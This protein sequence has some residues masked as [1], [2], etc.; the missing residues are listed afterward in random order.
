MK[1]ILLPFIMLVLAINCKAQLTIT[2]SLTTSQITTLL[3]GFGVTVSGL[4]VNCDPLAMGEFNGTSEMAIT[5]GIVLTT[6]SASA[7]AG[8]V[9]TT[10]TAMPGTA[11]DTDLD[12]LSGSTTFDACVLEFDCL[13]AGDTL[14]FN[15]SFGSEE[16]LEYV[17]TFNDVFAIFISGPGIVGT[18]NCATIPGGIPVAINNVNNDTNS[19][20]YYNNENP[21]GQYIAY[22]GFTTNLTAFAQVIPGALYHFKVAIAD[23]FDD[24]A[25][26]GVFLEAF[27]FRSVLADPTGIEKYRNDVFTVYP[28][29]GTGMF[30]LTDKG[31]E[32]AGSTVNVLNVLG[33]AV[34]SERI[35]NE[36]T[37]LDL[38]NFDSGIYFVNVVTTEGLIS[39]KIIKQ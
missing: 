31:Q 25:D 30:V 10:A 9:F 11:G 35:T 18:V 8:N 32:L 33:E 13:P 17:G 7:T 6:G 28:N 29:P 22:D 37:T 20:Y 2:D 24:M 4:T 16:Y 26:S 15:F 36:K 23:A 38:T 1:K 39:S 19:V 21:A 27:S 34:I 14:M 3:E 5:H 12:S